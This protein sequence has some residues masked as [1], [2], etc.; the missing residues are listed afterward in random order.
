MPECFASSDVLLR[1][2]LYKLQIVFY[3]TIC[4]IIQGSRG[5]GAKLWVEIGFV[6]SDCVFEHVY[7]EVHHGA[8]YWLQLSNLSC[9]FSSRFAIR[10]CCP[11]YAMSFDQGPSFT[12]VT[13]FPQ[14]YGYKFPD[15]S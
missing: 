7:M 8:P 11:N 6:A 15:I 3:S 9:R 12:R 4:T 10:L 13:G 2:G 1:P 14:N 5:R